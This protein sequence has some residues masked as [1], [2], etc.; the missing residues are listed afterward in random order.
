VEV[1]GPHVHVPAVVIN[2][3]V[4]AAMV[5]P[6]GDRPAAASTD[7]CTFAAST[8][9]TL[10]DGSAPPLPQP[11]SPSTA[12][13]AAKNNPKRNLDSTSRWFDIR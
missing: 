3:P 10:V 12:N 4:G 11:D 5:V 8:E 6:S 7:G 2:D 9:L 13:M 1:A